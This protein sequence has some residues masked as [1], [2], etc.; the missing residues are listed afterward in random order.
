MN[1]RGKLSALLR[2]GLA[3]FTIAGCGVPVDGMEDPGDDSLA[4]MALASGTGLAAQYFTGTAFD[5]SVLQRTDARV[6]FDW[7]TGSPGTGLPVDGFSVR[8]TG[9]VEAP[10]TDEVTDEVVTDEVVTDEVEATEVEATD[11]EA[12]EA[13]A[14]EA[15]ADDEDAAGDADGGEEE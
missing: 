9:Q 2:S 3:L 5:R 6:N 1:T 4:E 14:D 12:D 7:G 15:A 13:E 8:W 10:A 11:G